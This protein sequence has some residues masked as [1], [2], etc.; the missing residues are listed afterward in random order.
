MRVERALRTPIHPSVEDTDIHHSLSELT[1]KVSGARKTREEEESRRANAARRAAVA[2]VYVT[3]TS[4]PIVRMMLADWLERYQKEAPAF[5][6]FGTR[7]CTRRR[8]CVWVRVDCGV[9]WAESVG[10][11]LA[12]SYTVQ[13]SMEK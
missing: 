1:S 13:R 9:G 5:S 3:L 8:L 4:A 11:F 10:L 7:T 6:S 12:S 2:G